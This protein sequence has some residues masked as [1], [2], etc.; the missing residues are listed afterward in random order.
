MPTIQRHLAVAAAALLCT[1]LVACADPNHSELTVEG[2]F[3]GS[4]ESECVL[5]LRAAA[6]GKFVDS[7]TVKAEFREVF[8]VE[9]EQR[10]YYAQV[11]CSDGKWARSPDFQFHPPRS[12][13]KLQQILVN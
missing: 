10:S 2:S 7:A 5:S 4:D 11:N 9:P 12:G 3:T 8:E 1:G 6:D 13:I